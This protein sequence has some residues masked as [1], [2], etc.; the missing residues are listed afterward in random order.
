[1]KPSE[2]RGLPPPSR[3]VC[4]INKEKKNRRESFLGALTLVW[5]QGDINRRRLAIEWS[6]QLVQWWEN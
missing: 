4:I 3:V 1:V 6:R 2:L 5:M